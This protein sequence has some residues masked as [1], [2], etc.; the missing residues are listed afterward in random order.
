MTRFDLATYHDP[1]TASLEEA[2][3]V[4]ESLRKKL[5]WAN[6]E[7]AAELREDLRTWQRVVARLKGENDA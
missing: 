3:Y 2:E 5:T 7:Y 6:G 4:V 1:R